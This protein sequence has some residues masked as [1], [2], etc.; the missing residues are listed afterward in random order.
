MNYVKYNRNFVMMEEQSKDF[1]AKDS[2]V[3]GYLKIETGN[4]KGAL[5]CVVQNL[6]YHSRGDYI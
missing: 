1:T 3:K 6:K 4:N 5:R 2:P